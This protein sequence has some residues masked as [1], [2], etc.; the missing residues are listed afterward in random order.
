LV[1]EIQPYQMLNRILRRAP[2]PRPAS[3]ALTLRRLAS[4]TAA[5]AAG[6]IPP[7]LFFERRQP[8]EHL[9]SGHGILKGIRKTLAA[10]ITRLSGR[11]ADPR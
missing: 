10:S 4:I 11:R 1:K 2:E 7:L 3:K 5:M 6:A 8:A 9:R